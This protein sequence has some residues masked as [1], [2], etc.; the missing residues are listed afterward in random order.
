MLCCAVAVEGVVEEQWGAPS[1]HYTTTR[2]AC[3]LATFV[4]ASCLMMIL[5]ARNYSSRR[6]LRGMMSRFG[7][8]ECAITAK[9]VC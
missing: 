1:M 8:F 5:V 7:L 6:F 3:L 2:L 4:L 9:I